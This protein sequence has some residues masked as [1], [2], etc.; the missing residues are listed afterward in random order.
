[1]VGAITSAVGKAVGVVAAVGDSETAELLTGLR[2]FGR[3]DV[4]VINPGIL[5][6]RVL[7][8]VGG[9]RSQGAPCGP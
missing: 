1:M 9:E 7:G 2:E 5:P 4:L 3:L 8:A 6:D